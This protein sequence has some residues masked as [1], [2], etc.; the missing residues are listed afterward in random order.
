MFQEVG[1]NYH[2]IVHPDLGLIPSVPVYLSLFSLTVQLVS[3]VGLVTEI[4]TL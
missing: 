4:D 1:N 2:C 3:S